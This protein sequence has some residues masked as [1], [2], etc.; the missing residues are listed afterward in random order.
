[1]VAGHTAAVWLLSG[2]EGRRE[3]AGMRRCPNLW[4][5]VPKEM[6]LLEQCVPGIWNQYLRSENMHSL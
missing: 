4:T 6:P 2:R 1:M 5:W 3:G